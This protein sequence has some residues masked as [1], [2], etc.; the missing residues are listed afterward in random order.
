[1]RVVVIADPGERERAAGLLA[2]L[3]KAG[4]DAA[5][6][7]LRDP[8][9]STR[10]GALASCLV[11]V[12]AALDDQP[13]DAVALVG[14]GDRPFAAALVATK[15]EVTVFCLEADQGPGGEI[16]AM[17][18]RLADHSVAADPAEAVRAIAAALPAAS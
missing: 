17:I 15:S 16:A 13:A 10:T 2:G 3:S 14:S 12:E 9:A 18:A 4:F 11:A 7:E 6:L 5:E 8:G 1:M